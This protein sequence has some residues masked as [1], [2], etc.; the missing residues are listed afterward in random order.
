MVESVKYTREL[1]RENPHFSL[2]EILC[3]GVCRG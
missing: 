1:V 2:E 3:A